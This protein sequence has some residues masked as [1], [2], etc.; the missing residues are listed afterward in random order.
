MRLKQ[1]QAHQ[2]DA[3]L[4][5]LA[6]WNKTYNLTSVRD[7]SQWVE[8]HLMDSLAVLPWVK[9]TH[10]LDVGSGA[11][12]PGI[13]L[14]VALP[15]SRFTLL[16]ANSKKTRFLRQVML[17]LPL[18]NVRVVQ[19]RI[20]RFND[21]EAFET[22]TARAFSSLADYWQQARHLLAME[23]VMLAMKGKLC[24]DELDHLMSLQE[25]PQVSVE[26]LETV[27]N[28]QRHLYILRRQA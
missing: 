5:L 14:A 21:S 27:G 26:P 6:K 12:L 20:E 9:G 10:I 2:L 18:N 22:I 4:Q 25:P 24:D 13:P 23:G 17:Q 15:D 7:E 3:Y 28:A 19:E 8:R 11:G 16:D 1:E